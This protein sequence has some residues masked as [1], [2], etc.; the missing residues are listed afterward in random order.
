MLGHKG[1]ESGPRAKLKYPLPL[2]L[3]FPQDI[4]DVL[5]QNVSSF[6][7]NLTS[8]VIVSR[9]RLQGIDFLSEILVFEYDCLV[10]RVHEKV[11]E[12][13]PNLFILYQVS[14]C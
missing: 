3:S 4:K 13:L 5:R 2:Q 7:D 8:Q 12:E 11:S 10:V 6:P 14:E 1:A 9:R